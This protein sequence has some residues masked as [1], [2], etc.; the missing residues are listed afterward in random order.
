MILAVDVQYDEEAGTAH[1]GGV[2][3]SDWAQAVPDGK[4][5]VDVTG[6][7]PYVPGAFYL[8]ELPCIQALLD[9]HGILPDTILVDGYVTLKDGQPGL[10]QHLHNA[11]DG[12]I[13]VVGLAKTYFPSDGA[14]TVCRGD[15]KAPLFV[16]SIG[17]PVAEVAEAVRK[18]HG[19]YRIPTLLKLVDQIARNRA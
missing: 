6:I 15:S 8:R 3:F 19:P 5:T 17:L 9:Q 12:A 1:V 18:M 16:T 11:L 7:A 13:P 4:Y 14:V 10:G 2:T